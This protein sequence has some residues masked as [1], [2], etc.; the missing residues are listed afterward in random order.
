LASGQNF[1]RVFKESSISSFHQLKK[2][3]PKISSAL[4][5]EC[6]FYPSKPQGDRIFTL[7][8]K[9]GDRKFPKLIFPDRIPPV[10]TEY[11]L[12]F[13]LKGPSIRPYEGAQKSIKK[14]WIISPLQ[15]FPD[16]TFIQI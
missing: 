1:S 7:F 6:P 14:V 9:L 5:A 13:F 3:K 4:R 2:Y 16:K 10:E 12:S 8:L 11:F 15:N